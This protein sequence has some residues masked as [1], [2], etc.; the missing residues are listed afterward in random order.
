VTG[1]ALARLTEALE[2]HGC[3]VRGS[4]AQCPA[5]DD[6]QASLSIDQGRDGA[7]LKCHA[8]H[9]CTTDAIL[10]ALG[11]SAA[12]L[13]DEPRGQGDS[14]K[15]V[16]I[17]RYAYTDEA[18][19]PLFYSARFEP[20]RFRQYHVEQGREVWDLRGVRRVLYRLPQVIAAVQRGETIWIAE[21][22]K[23]VEALEKAGAVATCNP[24]GASKW[25]P[26]YA[27]VLDGASVIVV[28]DRDEPGRRHAAEV[29][30]SLDRKALAVTV[31]EAA[32]GK[33]AADHLAAGLSL[34]DFRAVQLETD[35]S[36]SAM[37]EAGSPLTSESDASDASDSVMD[38]QLLAGARDGAWLTAQDFPA[39]AYAVDGLIPEGLTLEVGPPKA[40]KSWLTLGLLLA[41]ASGGVALSRIKAAP[42]RR[43]F[44]LALEDG[45]RRMQ[46]RCRALLGEGEPIP[47][48]FHYQTRIMPGMVLPT[49]AAWMRRHP[50]TAMIV[51]DTLGKVMP[52]ALQGESAYQRDYRVGAALKAQADAHPGLAVLVLHHDRKAAADDFVDSVS[53]THGLAGAADTI[54][55]LSRRRHSPEGLLKVTGRDVPEA[56]YALKV[57]DGMGWQLD[58]DGL[59]AAAAKAREREEAQK[60]GETSAQILAAIREHPEGIRA[61]DLRDRFGKDVYQYLKRLTEAGRIDKL[62]RGLY[63]LLSEASE[64]SEPQASDGDSQSDSSSGLSDWPDGTAGAEAQR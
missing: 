62:E 60:L 13:F 45:D 2:A 14:R 25:Q 47:A 54:I 33:D 57:I 17:R 55:V 12:D 19:V 44:Y 27:D 38:A 41:V 34:N 1:D 49:I 22:E 39:L 58:G 48:L 56:E 59:A 28:A 31:V 53:G 35:T 32:D 18:G 15:P 8:S 20:K 21:G 36:D 4:S 50:D 5:H 40:G 61:A 9:G 52:P 63:V 46:D 37:S 26:E 23:D 29:A 10:E 7:I 51:V 3:T 6:R 30:A 16:I 42:P 43:V 64:P 11:M 24:M